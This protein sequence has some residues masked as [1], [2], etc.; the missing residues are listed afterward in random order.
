MLIAVML[1]HSDPLLLQRRLH[2]LRLLT[3]SYE[4]P[5]LAKMVFFLFRK[6]FMPLPR[7]S[8]LS[9]VAKVLF[10]Q[11]SVLSQG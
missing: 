1:P 2:T 8:G 4:V 3:A 9:L 7:Q 6:E 5:R 11:F 10:I